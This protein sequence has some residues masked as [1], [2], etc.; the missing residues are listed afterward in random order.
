MCR[1]AAYL[2]PEIALAQFLLAPP[3]SL[4]VQAW[5]PKELRYA[6][7]NA[8]GFG[9]GW[10]GMDDRAVHYVSSMPIWS[11]LNL[12]TLAGNLH[13]DLWIAAVRSATPGL[14]SHP[15]NTQPFADGD[16]LFSHNGYLEDFTG[17][18]RPQMQRWM[19]PEA[20]GH[21]SGTTDSEYLFS[22][23]RQLLDEDE[24]LPVEAALGEAFNLVGEWVDGKAALLNVI[25]TDGER[26]YA[27]RHAINHECPSLYYTTDDDSFPEGAQLVA[28]EPLTEAGLWRSVPEHHILIL[29]PEAPPELLAL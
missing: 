18:V 9:F 7:L 16:F 22:V 14:T 3:H 2:G 12:P 24:E 13:S 28:S 4:E 21:I 15:V 17:L 19:S 6:R 5:A 26:V 20:E 11:D 23:V 1:H 29:D 27:S 8:D 25:M 10:Y